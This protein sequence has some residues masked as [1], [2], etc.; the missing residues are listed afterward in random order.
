MMNDSVPAGSPLIT[1]RAKRTVNL[2]IPADMAL[3]AA[4][5]GKTP[6]IDPSLANPMTMAITARRENPWSPA[7]LSTYLREVCR[8][9]ALRINKPE[10]AAWVK[11]QTDI[12]R[13]RITETQTRVLASRKDRAA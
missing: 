13:R 10:L 12:A 5:A 9:K 8:E 7:V 6:Q 2:N 4:L 11:R 1:T 3:Y